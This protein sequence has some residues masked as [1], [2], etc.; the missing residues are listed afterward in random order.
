M[1]KLLII[2]AIL[3]IAIFIFAGCAKTTTT[4]PP[5]TSPPPSSTT[6][7]SLPPS[8]TTS[9]SPPPTSTIATSTVTTSTTSTETPV[10]GGTLRVIMFSNPL[11]IGD[12][13]LITD[14]ASNMGAIPDLESLVFSDNDGHENGVLATSWTVAPDGK[15]ITFALRKG[16]TFHDGTSFNGTVAKWNLD[17]YMAANPGICPRM[18]QRRCHRRVHHQA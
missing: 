1:K 3:S 14:S 10:Y 11:Y 8:S 2:L 15:S 12:P 4:S 5:P 17:R 18:V 13:T 6:S 9:A 16:V 7:T